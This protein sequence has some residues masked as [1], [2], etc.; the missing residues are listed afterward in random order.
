MNDRRRSNSDTD[1]I[2]DSIAE[3]GKTHAAIERDLEWIKRDHERFSR[4]VDAIQEI[5]TIAKDN[6]SK[7]KELR[8]DYE[9]LRDKV[10][11]TEDL[12]ASVREGSASEDAQARS[13][14]DRNSERID[15]LE[16]KFNALE[17]EDKEE[18]REH[19]KM[20]RKDMALVGLGGASGGALLSR[21]PEIIEAIFDISSK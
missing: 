3:L 14:V 7:V 18:L 6:Q 1:S 10:D 21:I 9:S 19:R 16:T 5:L 20:S 11:R 4:A 17:K 2:I 15:V 12:I 13:R 8:K